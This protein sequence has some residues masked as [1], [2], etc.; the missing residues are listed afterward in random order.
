MRIAVL[1]GGTSAD[2]DALLT[3]LEADPAYDI[4]KFDVGMA[5]LP[6]HDDIPGAPQNTLADGP[7]L[8]VAAGKKP[9]EYKV[10]A[11]FVSFLLEATR[12]DAPWP[13]RG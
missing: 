13:V 5:S 3:L 1:T 6:Y 7:A 8:W 4:A 11:K 2:I 12:M 10:I 9:E